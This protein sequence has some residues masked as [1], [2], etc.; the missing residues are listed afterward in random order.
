VQF[1]DIHKG[2][3][4]WE[5]LKKKSTKRPSKVQNAVIREK[6]SERYEKVRGNTLQNAR[7]T[8]IT[9]EILQR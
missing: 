9:R 5:L 2:T 7:Y 8:G 1:A 4:L 3:L 6:I